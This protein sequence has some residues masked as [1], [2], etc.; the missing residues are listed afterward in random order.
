[1]GAALNGELLRVSIGQLH[2]T[3]CVPKVQWPCEEI[4]LHTNSTYLNAM[5][6]PIHLMSCGHGL[7]IIEAAEHRSIYPPEKP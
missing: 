1:M 6:M 2:K 4:P 3:P 7:T 5:G